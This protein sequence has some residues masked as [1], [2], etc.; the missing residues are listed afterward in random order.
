MEVAKR[1]RY[2]RS[3][4]RNSMAWATW[5]RMGLVIDVSTRPMVLVSRLTSDLAM[6]LGR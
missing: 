2:P 4:S 6:W 3:A 5:V 1:V